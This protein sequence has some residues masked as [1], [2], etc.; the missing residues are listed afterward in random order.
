M[1]ETNSRMDED[2]DKLLIFSITSR[3]FHHHHHHCRVRHHQHSLR[4][5]LAIS[6]PNNR[7]FLYWIDSSPHSQSPLMSAPQV[8]V[9][10]FK[11]QMKSTSQTHLGCHLLSMKRLVTSHKYI[12]CSS[13]FLCVGFLVCQ[14]FQETL[15]GL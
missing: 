8:P 2:D 13:V 14:G 11:D 6:T 4:F 1:E 9:L 7:R 3:V 15:D 5:R 12:G 10:L